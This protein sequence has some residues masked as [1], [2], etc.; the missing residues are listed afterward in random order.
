MLNGQIL[1]PQKH[2]LYKKTS[3]HN[4]AERNSSE[5]VRKVQKT[6]VVR[7]LMDRLDTHFETEDEERRNAEKEKIMKTLELI[8]YPRCFVKQV[9]IKKKKVRAKRDHSAQRGRDTMPLVCALHPG[10]E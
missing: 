2:A 5:N 1:C 4:R 6:S 8:G 10:L 7:S 3:F 9:E